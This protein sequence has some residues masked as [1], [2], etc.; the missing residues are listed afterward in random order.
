MLNIVKKVSK[1]S[2]TALKMYFPV[3]PGAHGRIGVTVKSV[4]IQKNSEIA[5]VPEM[6]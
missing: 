4:V 2:N 5:I 3:P 1:R 6:I